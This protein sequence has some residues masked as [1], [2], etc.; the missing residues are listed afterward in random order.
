L[1]QLLMM[2]FLKNQED[3]DCTG[4]NPVMDAVDDEK[5]DWNITGVDAQIVNN[6]ST[7]QWSAKAEGQAT[8][9]IMIDDV[10]NPADDFPTAGTPLTVTVVRPTDET[11]ASNGWGSGTKQT[12]HLWRQRLQPTIVNFSGIEVI[13][14]DNGNGT[15]ACYF[16]G[17]AIQPFKS[18]TGAHWTVD[19]NNYWGDDEVG[20]YTTAVTYYRS[21]NRAPCCQTMPQGMD[22]VIPTG[23]INYTNNNDLGSCIDVT[24][25]NSTRDGHTQT[26]TWP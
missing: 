24:T 3:K 12:M 16:A 6:Q 5:T 13:E 21:Q 20:W 9:N 18:I 22:V 25:V 26:K 10:G 17:S 23:N 2:F 7:V 8:F 11:T 19:D 1:G 14:R 4:G 15:D